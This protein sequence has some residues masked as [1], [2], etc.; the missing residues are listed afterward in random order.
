MNA[1]S[2]SDKNVEPDFDAWLNDPNVQKQRGESRWK[3]DKDRP[4]DP[5]P[6]NPPEGH[7]L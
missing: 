2:D 4:P 1:P 5:E 7:E 6:N 3:V